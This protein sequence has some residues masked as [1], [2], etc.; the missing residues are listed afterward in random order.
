MRNRKDGK[1]VTNLNGMNYIM[2]DILKRRVDNEVYGN[3]SIDVTE[4]LKYLEKE[5]KKK[6]VHITCF[7]AFSTAIAKVIYNRPYLNRFIVNGKF[8][9][10]NNVTVSFVAKMEFNDDSQEVMQVIKALED[11]NIFTFS[12]KIGKRVHESRN[13]ETSSTDDLVSKVGKL[14]RL[15][16]YFVVGCYKWADKHDLL[17]LSMTEEIIYYSSAVVSNIGSIGSTT[18]IYHHLSTFGTNSMLITMGKIYQKEVILDNGKKEIRS[19]CDFGITLDERIADGFYMIKSVQLLEY[20]LAHPK[21]LEEKMEKKI[22]LKE[23]K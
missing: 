1:V 19:F 5:N 21:L 22:T 17:P 3:Y 15:L 6:D 2:H 10:R 7:H 8:Y 12:K 4:L 18:A 14:P 11:D 9:D 20:L 13:S 16:R 23:G